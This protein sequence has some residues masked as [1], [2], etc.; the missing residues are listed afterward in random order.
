MF[1]ERIDQ[2]GANGARCS[3]DHDVHAEVVP[4]E[5]KVVGVLQWW[6]VVGRGPQ[7]LDSRVVDLASEH[8]FEG[9]FEA[10]KKAA[11]HGLLRR[12]AS[13]GRVLLWIHYLKFDNVQFELNLL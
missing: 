9:R 13:C 3:S 6:D 5:L 12:L 10:P 1:H 11:Q 2:L 7:I 8:I 4:P